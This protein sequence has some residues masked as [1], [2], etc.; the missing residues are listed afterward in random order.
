MSTKKKL[1]PGDAVTWK[2][3]GTTVDGTVEKKLTK[4]TSIKGHDVAASPKNPE[5]LVVSAKTGAR[6]A[7]KPAALKKK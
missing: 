5:Y 7:H 6:A 1:A 2:S 3:R 4:P